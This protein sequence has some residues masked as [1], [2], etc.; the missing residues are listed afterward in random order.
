MGRVPA[1]ARAVLPLGWRKPA[2]GEQA[3]TAF[4]ERYGR[5]L[6]AACKSLGEDLPARLAHLQL[7]WR[8]RKFLRTTNLCERSFVEERRRSKT[9]PR[10]FTERSC[11]K[12]VF[13]MLIRA[14]QRWQ[15]I[16]ITPLEQAQLYRER[17][18]TLAQPIRQVA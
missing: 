18:L 3:V 12:L 14:A 1:P 9:L 5:E 4:L 2:A 10:F 8:L 7:P 15:R 6:P 17:G 13:A 16:A 11:V